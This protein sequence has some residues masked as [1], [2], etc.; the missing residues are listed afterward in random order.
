MDDSTMKKLHTK[1]T[2]IRFDRVPPQDVDAERALLGSLIEPTGNNEIIEKAKHIGVLPEIFYK[3]AHEYI[4]TAIFNLYEKE[5]PVDLVTLTK[6]LMGIGLLEQVGDVSYLD[7]I[8]DTALTCVNMAYYAE[9]VKEN[10]LKRSAIQQ[11]VKL[12]NDAFEHDIE[13]DYLIEAWS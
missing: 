4:C 5:T 1:E 6:E 7:E 2:G 10:A 9:I 3:K 11:A 8:V 13:I 12:Y